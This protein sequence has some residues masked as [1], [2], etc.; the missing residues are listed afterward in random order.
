MS[1]LQKRKIH[2]DILLKNVAEKSF[3]DGHDGRLDESPEAKSAIDALRV[4]VIELLNQAHGPEPKHRPVN[5]ELYMLGYG[6]GSEARAWR[7]DLERNQDYA[8]GFEMGIHFRG[9]S[10]RAFEEE[11]DDE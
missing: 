10:M 11:Q 1:M 3:S 7:G 4:A 6:H 5:R 9:L 2:L 8:F